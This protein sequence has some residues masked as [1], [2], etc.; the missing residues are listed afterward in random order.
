MTKLTGYAPV[1]TKQQST[2]RR[3]ADLMRTGVRRDGD[4]RSLGPRASRAQFDRALD[5]LIGRA[6]DT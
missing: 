2:D 3:L 5:A 1:S 6:S 4:H